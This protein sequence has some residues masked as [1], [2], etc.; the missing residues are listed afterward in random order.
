MAANNGFYKFHFQRVHTFLH[1]EV[2]GKT[3]TLAPMN[4]NWLEKHLQNDPDALS[5]TLVTPLGHV[6]TGKEDNAAERNLLTAS[7]AELQRFLLK[8]VDT[9]GAFGDPIELKKIVQ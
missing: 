4:P 6:P 1:V 2:D 7:T 9:E 5:H 8:H 3:L